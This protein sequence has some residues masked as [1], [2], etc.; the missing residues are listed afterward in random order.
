MGEVAAH[1]AVSKTDFTT[2]MIVGR[3]GSG[4]TLHLRSLQISA[5]NKPDF[6][7]IADPGVLLEHT[8]KAVTL[9]LGSASPQSVWALLWRRAIFSFLG[10]LFYAPQKQFQ[11]ALI[12]TLSPAI[13]EKVVRSRFS[14]IFNCPAIA[15]T[16]VQ[17]VDTIASRFSRSQDLYNY[18]TNP[19]WNEFEGLIAAS[20]HNVAPIFVFIDALDSRAE[21]FPQL[22]N[23]CQQG[24]F[25]TIFD[26]LN[27]SHFGGR[28]HIM[29]TIRDAVYRAILRGEGGMNVHGDSHLRILNWGW[30]ETK[31]FLEKKIEQLSTRVFHNVKRARSEKTLENWLGFDIVANYKRDLIE[32]TEQY[33]FRHTRALPRDI[34]MLG[35]AISREKDQCK[36]VGRDFTDGHLRKCVE[37]TSRHFGSETIEICTTEL[38]LTRPSISEYSRVLRLAN[39]DIEAM[40]LSISDMIGEFVTSIGTEIFS[41]KQLREALQKI[42][43]G[44]R[45]T[46]DHGALQF[47]RIEN[48]LWR[49]GMIAYEDYRGSGRKAKWIFEW[50]TEAEGDL[51]PSDTERYGFHPCL[52]DLFGLKNAGADIVY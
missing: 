35:N 10:S 24:L 19:L 37:N 28:L 1:L 25:V 14:S 18:L 23:D 22:W 9:R 50:Y 49:N 45:T 15:I 3:R 44:D 7:S 43:G 40:R 29:T 36:S 32:S 17:Y 39:E 16:P 6:I 13:D 34:V 47:Y 42:Y 46:F 21:Q 11:I 30:H 52:I 51:L 33:I 12:S 26:I 27:H 31:Y 5:I 41:K 20:M 48:V 38:L 2:H 4:K 8:L